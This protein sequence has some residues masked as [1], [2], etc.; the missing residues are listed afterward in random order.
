[1]TAPHSTPSESP[2][3]PACGSRRRPYAWWLA[4]MYFVLPLAA[5]IVLELV[6]STK[7]KPWLEFFGYPEVGRMTGGRELRA[8]FIGTSRV[9]AAIDAQAFEQRMEEK[10]YP[11]YTTLN[12]GAGGSRLHTH[13]LGLRALLELDSRA[14]RGTTIFIEA[15]DGLP[16]FDTW[17]DPWVYPVMAMFT[18]RYMQAG[19]LGRI[20]RSHMPL[21]DRLDLTFR[22]VFRFSNLV[23]YRQ[24][25]RQEMLAWVRRGLEGGTT[26]LGGHWRERAAVNSSDTPTSSPD[27]GVRPELLDIARRF[28]GDRVRDEGASQ[29]PVEDWE[30]TV[31]ASIVHQVQ[32]AG[33]Q[34][35]FYDM[36]QVSFLNRLVETPVRRRDRERFVEAASRWGTPIVHPRFPTSD[37]DF[38]D[39]LH[40]G[41]SKAREFSRSLADSW[42]AQEG[43]SR[44]SGS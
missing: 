17:Q 7:P 35:V 5:V 29:R 31:V 19:D 10:G 33:G 27:I 30:R 32:L 23:T 37:G 1:M 9:L 2:P 28:I 24:L 39:L 18:V 11:E 13:A 43:K 41:R 6:A 42:L 20:W 3:V 44:G 26:R 4:W 21:G 22:I 15:P 8:L 40:L 12:L 16:E 25:V 34:V 14:L 36:P 38:P